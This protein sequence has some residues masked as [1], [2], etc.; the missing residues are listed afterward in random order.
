MS[1]TSD[2]CFLQSNDYTQAITRVVTQYIVHYTDNSGRKKSF[3]PCQLTGLTAYVLASVAYE[4][5]SGLCLSTFHGSLWQLMT[6]A[7]GSSSLVEYQNGTPGSM[8][9]NFIK[10]TNDAITKL[11]CETNMECCVQV[12]H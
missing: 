9:I 12:Q 3:K 6:V 5:C 10:M 1:G 8:S 11:S 4:F 2:V 7:W